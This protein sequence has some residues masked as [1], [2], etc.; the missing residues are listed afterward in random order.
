MTFAFIAGGDADETVGSLR[1]LT[2]DQLGGEGIGAQLRDF[3]VKNITE[4]SAEL[5]PQQVYIVRANGHADPGGF[6]LDLEVTL[7]DRR[8]DGAVSADTAAPS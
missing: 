3:L 2:A 1:A 7:G 4:N 5:E 8:T 6:L